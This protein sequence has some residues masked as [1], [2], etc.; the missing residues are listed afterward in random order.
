MAGNTLKLQYTGAMQVA[1]TLCSKRKRGKAHMC[2]Q[3]NHG[4]KT[5]ATCW[6]QSQLSRA[7][8]TQIIFWR[9][10]CRKRE[11]RHSFK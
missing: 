4:L 9:K 3:E 8:H 7:T 11:W 6:T 10:F 5:L 1:V 2:T